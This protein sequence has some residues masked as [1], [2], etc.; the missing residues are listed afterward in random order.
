MQVAA[1][2]D[3][4]G[5]GGRLAD[6]RLQTLV[7]DHVLPIDLRQ[8]LSDTRLVRIDDTDQTRSR[9]EYEEGILEALSWLGIDWDEDGAVDIDLP[10]IG[11]R[12]QPMTSTTTGTMRLM[13][14]NGMEI[15]M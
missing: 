12:P 6:H 1:S 3:G 5:V 9:P 11:R 2:A 15:L 10:A 13:K 14:T 7:K 4:E 8:A